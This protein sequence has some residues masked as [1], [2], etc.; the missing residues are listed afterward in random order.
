MPEK[1]AEQ[2]IK[3]LYEL[4]GTPSWIVG[5]VISAPTPADVRTACL[6][7]NLEII[8]VPHDSVVL[9]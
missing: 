1:N 8:E 4:D 5:R 3:D 6:S 7:T 9:K 2:Y